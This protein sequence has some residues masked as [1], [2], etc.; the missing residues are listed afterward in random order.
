[1][2]GAAALV[3]VVIVAG[4]LVRASVDQPSASGATPTTTAANRSTATVTRRDLVSTTD[5]SGTL[6]YGDTRPLRVSGARSSSTSSSAASSSASASSST[7]GGTASASDAATG[8]STTAANVITALPAVGS[9]IDRGQ[10]VFEIDGAPGP[11]LLFGPRPMWRTLQSGVTD[12]LDVAQLELNLVALGFANNGAMTVDQRYSS[13]TAAAVA[14]WQ[15]SRGL[16]RTGVV[17]PSD[18]V[19]QRG[20]VRVASLTASTGD[21]ASGEIMQVTDTTR[22]VRVALTPANQAFVKLGATVDVT[23]PDARVV[24]GRAES[25]GTVANTS[26]SGQGNNQSTTTTVDLW[27]TLPKPPSNL[28]DDSPVTVSLVTA[29]ATGVLAVPVNAL[30]ALAEGGYGLEVAQPDGSTRLVGVQTGKFAGGWVEIRG[31]VA[32]GDRVVT[33]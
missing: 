16:A 9:V 15:A 18:V 1:M 32:A 20:P 4:L 3:V 12:G 11:A 29:R 14:D 22:R 7:A 33:A 28:L 10:T 19:V 17:N 31:A 13:A 23:L 6:T 25:I 24:K 2:V 30:L 27:I 5:V 8:T 21:S 26:T